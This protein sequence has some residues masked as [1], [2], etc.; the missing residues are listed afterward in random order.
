MAGRGEVGVFVSYR[1]DD[2]SGH[3]GRLYDHLASRLGHERVFMDLE[4]IQPGHDFVRAIEDALARCEAVI[5]LIGVRW[6]SAADADGERRLER[7]DDFVRLE[8]EAAL[9]RSLTIIP[10]LVQGARMPTEGEVPDS[11]SAVVRYQALE[12]TER[13]WHADVAILL[14]L[15]E[16]LGRAV[17][18]VGG[19]GT[20]PRLTPASPEAAALPS[21]LVSNETAP[22]VGRADVLAALTDRWQR[23]RDGRGGV[24]LV[25]GEPGIGKTRLCAALAAVVHAQGGHVLYGRCDEDLGV[26]YQ[27]VV[28]ALRHFVAT[29]P[30]DDLED[31]LGPDAGELTRL[32][33]Q[34]AERAP[35]IP[36]PR[37]ADAESERYWLFE[38]IVGWL[39]A[40][41]ARR[42]LLLVLDDLHWATKATVL[43]LRHLV[44]SSTPTG[45]L[46]V[47]TYRDTEV[48]LAHALAD[49]VA[50][51]QVAPNVERLE[52][53]G[54]DRAA[55]QS[56][57]EAS[58]GDDR[59]AENS[60][61]ELLWDRT[62]GNPFFVL[63]T[64]RHLD[65]GEGVGGPSLS[66][67]PQ[68]V[69][70]VVDRRVQRLSNAGRGVLSVGAI[71]GSTFSLRL[72]ERVVADADTEE[73]LDALDDAV[74]A[75]LLVELR[76]SPGDYSFSHALIREAVYEGITHARR[77]RLHI[78][79]GEALEAFS[80]AGRV[81]LPTSGTTMFGTSRGAVDADG[82][83]L[84]A[85]AHHFM[86]AGEDET[87][88]KAVRYATLAA[89]QALDELALDEAL[90]LLDRSRHVL[91]RSPVVDRV[92]AADLFLVLAQALE[93]AG[94]AA[95]HEAAALH[96]ADEARSAPS[97]DRLAMAAIAATDWMTHYDDDRRSQALCEEALAA[98][99][100]DFPSLRA[101]VL[102]SLADLSS[103]SLRSAPTRLEMAKE[104]VQIAR[105]AHDDEV[106]ADALRVYS[107]ALWGSH[108]VE[109]KAELADELLT[110]SERTGD[111]GVRLS[112]LV[113]RERVQV[114]LGDFGRFEALLAEMERFAADRRS[115]DAETDAIVGRAFLALLHGRF[116]DAEI[117][118]ARALEVSH[119]PQAPNLYGQQL[120]LIRREQGR[121]GEVL[122][123]VEHA[124]TQNPDWAVFR[125]ALA[126]V[127]AE[128]GALERART[129]FESLASDGFAAAPPNGLWTITMS[130]L[131]DVCASLGDTRR[132]EALYDLL[133]PHSGHL[134]IVG[135]FI[136]CSGAVDR[137]LAALAATCGRYEPA[138]AH[139]RSALALEE[140]ISAPPLV[141]RTQLWYARLLVERSGPGDPERASELLTRAHETARNLG[142]ALLAEQAAALQGELLDR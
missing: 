66:A 5:A 33:P 35:T 64:L 90:A 129:E 117:L 12:L 110:I 36:P 118:A 29:S 142:M 53:N 52:L 112:G 80:D 75:R 39:A 70:A 74:A 55:V 13:H 86:A 103:F 123:A 48:S 94:D 78:R 114:E 41:S 27:P 87:A 122:T 60:L 136:A 50:D 121:F 67:V 102:A 96:A 100:S 14:R 109:T 8:L 134:V 101:R 68:G 59:R 15:L 113:L 97:P 34:L 44:R 49:L 63:E 38:A 127:H 139:F 85:L 131:A 42:P 91:D 92:L 61:V 11:L 77:S 107:I 73:L 71:V 104:A 7:H 141:A 72:L 99:G 89:R 69:R 124:V 9:E 43:L 115:W 116:D 95:G 6:L 125:A 51:V 126:L 120:A 1:R 132:A 32:V 4:S 133:L 22:F 46:V 88:A 16:R 135:N 3:A 81:V 130:M 140:E 21:P 10:V 37:S 84:R 93:I 26:P 19:R 17:D 45:L 83:D 57:M 111:A 119:H 105:S 54:L 108:D 20:S 24:V 106:L 76:G 56:L 47:A 62:Q 98:L 58:G 31:A 138:E 40:A 23:A 82:V 65:D 79:V 25:A 128:A 18:Q 2:A 30:V 28:E 137:Y